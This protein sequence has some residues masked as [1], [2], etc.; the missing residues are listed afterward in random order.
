MD[1]ALSS[2]WQTV[3]LDDLYEKVFELFRSTPGGYSR[4]SG[5]DRKQVL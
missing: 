4:D 1:L 5:A 2:T 3:R